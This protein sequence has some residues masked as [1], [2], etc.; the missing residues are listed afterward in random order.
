MIESTQFI[1]NI[2]LKRSKKKTGNISTLKGS[3]H[4]IDEVGR[5]HGGILQFPKNTENRVKYYGPLCRLVVPH[6]GNPNP[7]RDP[8]PRGYCDPFPIF[9]GHNGNPNFT[10][11]YNIA[12]MIKQKKPFQ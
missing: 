10:V 4:G 2:T 11:V 6:S 9:I 7:N 12:L 8:I 1:E 3:K 5:M